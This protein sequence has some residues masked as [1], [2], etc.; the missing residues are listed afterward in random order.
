MPEISS[1]KCH[2]SHKNN[3]SEILVEIRLTKLDQQILVNISKLEDP[4]ITSLSTAC[5]TKYSS[6]PLASTILSFMNENTDF[7][8]ANSNFD[9]TTKGLEHAGNRQPAG[10]QPGELNQPNYLDD[11][12]SNL[13]IKLA[14]KFKRQFFVSWSV[15]IEVD[16]MKI[17]KDLFEILK[18]ELASA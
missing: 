14:G 9:A 16:E 7:K 3:F 2:A 17:E 4:K 10:F 18:L 15:P 8:S 12:S 6:L 1:Y 11:K 13:A 5:Q